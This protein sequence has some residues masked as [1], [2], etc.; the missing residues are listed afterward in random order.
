MNTVKDTET[1]SLNV[2]NKSGKLERKKNLIGNSNLD[3]FRSLNHQCNGFVHVY[4]IC[5]HYSRDV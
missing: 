3:A 4:T 1:L 5:S 2:G